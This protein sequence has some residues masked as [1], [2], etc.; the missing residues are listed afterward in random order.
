VLARSDIESLAAPVKVTTRDSSAPTTFEGVALKSVLEKAGV[1]VGTSMRRCCRRR[2]RRGAHRQ[3][4]RIHEYVGPSLFY[5]FIRLH[6][7]VDKLFLTRKT[8]S[9]R[10]RS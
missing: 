2:S 5:V 3:L 4:R 7:F 8:Q 6:G 1:E 10:D 9:E